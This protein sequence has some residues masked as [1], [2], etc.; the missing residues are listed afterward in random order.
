MKTFIL[1]FSL[2]I[3]SS[4]GNHHDHRHIG[5]GANNSQVDPG[6]MYSYQ[7]P[8]G[9]YESYT[10]YENDEVEYFAT[11]YS[12][13]DWLDWFTARGTYVINGSTIELD[14]EIKENNGGGAAATCNA[15]LGLMSL[16]YS[17]TPTSFTLQSSTTYTLTSIT[18]LTRP[19]VSALPNGCP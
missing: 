16:S 1:I 18:G 4:C 5:V 19:D 17:E 14:L 15:A 13:S 3:I 12:N 10:F 8:S 7:H 6:L 9:P 11:V 2:I